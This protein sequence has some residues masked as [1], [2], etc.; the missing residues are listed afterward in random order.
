MYLQDNTLE[1]FHSQALITFLDVLNRIHLKKQ[2]K[3]T[4]FS[5]YFCL[6][7]EKPCKWQHAFTYDETTKRNRPVTN[8]QKIKN[9]WSK[10]PYLA[11]SHLCCEDTDAIHPHQSNQQSFTSYSPFASFQLHLT[12]ACCCRWHPSASCPPLSPPSHHLLS[13]PK[14]SPLPFSHPLY[15]CYRPKKNNIILWLLQVK[16]RLR[17]MATCLTR[18]HLPSVFF[19]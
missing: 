19:I 6:L 16:C 18:L 12:T 2:L 8:V 15:L 5:Q 9:I 7:K 13:T 1:P 14:L 4:E 17:S 3:K 10:N 11:C